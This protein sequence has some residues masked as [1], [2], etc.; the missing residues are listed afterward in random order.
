MDLSD[1]AHIL[2]IV[3]RRRRAGSGSSNRR[4]RG[5]HSSGG[6]DRRHRGGHGVHRFRLGVSCPGETAVFV[7][8]ADRVGDCEAS[9]DLD[10]G[11][12]Q[13]LGIHVVDLSLGVP[14]PLLPKR[15][16]KGALAPTRTNTAERVKY[17]NINQPDRGGATTRLRSIGED[18]AL[19][20][21][22]FTTLNIYSFGSQKSYDERVLSAIRQHNASEL[23][24]CAP[25]QHRHTELCTFCR[26]SVGVEVEAPMDCNRRNCKR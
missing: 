23:L 16:A 10:V 11:E 1:T 5:G 17:S 14:L 7:G 18:E 4:R 6:S 15:R 19:H 3:R 2:V 20:P 26:R 9:A 13:E 12:G 22:I 8:S 25:W 21:M 24:A